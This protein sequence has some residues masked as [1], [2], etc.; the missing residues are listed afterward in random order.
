M[1]TEACDAM[2]SKYGFSH[3]VAQPSQTIVS[4]SCVSQAMFQNAQSIS[5][6]LKTGELARSSSEVLCWCLWI[7]SQ[8]RLWFVLGSQSVEWR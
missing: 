1:N 4:S 3:L 2:K 7:W 8:T 5:L 6:S